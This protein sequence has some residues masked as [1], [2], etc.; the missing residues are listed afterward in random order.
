MWRACWG[1]SGGLLSEVEAAQRTAR[2]ITSSEGDY[3][4]TIQDLWEV[5]E[6]ADREA[7]R[8]CGVLGQAYGLCGSEAFDPDKDLAI[9]WG[10]AFCTT[11]TRPGLKS[12][13][14]WGPG[15]CGQSWRWRGSTGEACETPEELAAVRAKYMPELEAMLESGEE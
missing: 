5:W 11:R 2:E 1:S 14:W 4:L 9:S 13:R 8:L 3:N 15:C 10:T 6:R 7:L 12:C